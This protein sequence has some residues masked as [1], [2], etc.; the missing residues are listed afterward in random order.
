MLDFVH[1][2]SLRTADATVKR[3]KTKRIMISYTVELNLSCFLTFGTLYVCFD[4]RFLGVE[5]VQN[6]MKE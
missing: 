3:K 5:K 1:I 6:N 2:I 4:D